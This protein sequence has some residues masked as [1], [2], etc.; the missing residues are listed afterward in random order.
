[1]FQI[2]Q[3][4]LRFVV[5]EVEILDDFQAPLIVNAAGD[6]VEPGPEAVCDSVDHPETRF[7][8]TLLRVEPAVRR[9]DSGIEDAAYGLIAEGSPIFFA[10]LSVGPGRHPAAAALTVRE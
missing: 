1:R 3:V 6:L 8:G 5:P 9:N 2:A 4:T 7:R 10:V